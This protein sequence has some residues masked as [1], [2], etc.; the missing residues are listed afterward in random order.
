MKLLLSCF[1][2][3]CDYSKVSEVYSTNFDGRGR[4]YSEPGYYGWD[5]YY[6]W[7]N[8]PFFFS[9]PAINLQTVGPGFIPDY[10]VFL[11]FEE[12][13]IDQH[14]YQLLCSREHWG[15]N[16]YADLVQTLHDA[17]RLRIESYQSLLEPYKDV[18][19]EAVKYDLGMLR[20]WYREFKELVL[21][22]RNSLTS[23]VMSLA[24]GEEKESLPK[25]KRPFSF[26]LNILS[27]G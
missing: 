4:Y 9:M 6:D 24:E 21:G 13:V 3:G 27:W 17:G 7:E 15:Y 16:E 5:R 23:L 2:L 8:E 20:S 22:G 11:L 26:A 10:P 19:K 18:I 14:T 25:R 1:G 12:F